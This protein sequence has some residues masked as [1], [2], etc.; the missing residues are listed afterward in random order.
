MWRAAQKSDAARRI[1]CWIEPPKRGQ[2]G[3]G[4]QRD[5]CEHDPD[6]GHRLAFL[7]LAIHAVNDAA[8]VGSG[9]SVGCVI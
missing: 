9:Q 2:G 3:E 5:H 7:P 8:W 4:R 6:F 1:A